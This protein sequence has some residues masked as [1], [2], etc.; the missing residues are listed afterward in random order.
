MEELQQLWRG[1][2]TRD[3]YSSPPADFSLRAIIIWCIHDYPALGTMSGR[4]THGYNACVR[5]DRNP[6][7]YAILRKI[8]YIGHRHFL[9][10]D[11]PHPRKYR[12]HVF[13]AKHENHDAPKRLTADELQVELEKVRHITPGNHPGNGSGKRKRGMV[14]RDYCLPA[15]PLCGTW[16]IGKIWIRGIILM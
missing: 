5:R 10:K 9:A 1:F 8:C 7:S 16:S 13:N 11:K 14:E 15:G 6:L 4:T 2:L 12:R 3:L